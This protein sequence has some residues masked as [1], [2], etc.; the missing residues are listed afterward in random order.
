MTQK[1]KKNSGNTYLLKDEKCL[2]KT[3]SAFLS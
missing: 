3:G 2:D 1:K